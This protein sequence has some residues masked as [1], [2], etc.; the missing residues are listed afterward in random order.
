MSW[1]DNGQ[2]AA[3]PAGLGLGHVQKYAPVVLALGGLASYP[4]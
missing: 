2:S 3:L 4:F 1:R